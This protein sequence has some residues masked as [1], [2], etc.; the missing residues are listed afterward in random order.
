ML[1]QPR[2]SKHYVNAQQCNRTY[3]SFLL[4]PF[5][6]FKEHLHDIVETKLVSCSYKYMRFPLDSHWREYIE[7]TSGNHTATT[8]TMEESRDAQNKSR[9]VRTLWNPKI[10]YRN[11]K[12][13]LLYNVYTHCT[14]LILYDESELFII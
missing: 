13:S 4:S 12:N 5:K 2:K 9:N 6:Y 8:D 14:F 7:V 1:G 11:H 3:V 10:H